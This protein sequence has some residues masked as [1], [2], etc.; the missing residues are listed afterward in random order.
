MLGLAQKFCL[1]TG[2][3]TALKVSMWQIPKVLLGMENR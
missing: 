1:T 2:P 3:L